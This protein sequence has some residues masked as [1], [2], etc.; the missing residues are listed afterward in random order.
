MKFF[1]E[2]VVKYERKIPRK[3]EDNSEN[4]IDWTDFN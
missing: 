4:Y 3:T 1:E 2:I